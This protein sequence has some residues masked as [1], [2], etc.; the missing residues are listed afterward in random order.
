L[1]DFQANIEK[2]TAAN[3]AIVAAS[4]D[5]REDAEK[6]ALAE[7]VTFPLAF[8]LDA[9]AVARALGSF[10]QAEDPYLHATGFMLHPDGTIARGVYSTGAVGRITADDCLRSI[11]RYNQQRK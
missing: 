6:M 9:L 10:Y 3:A 8:G 1:A 7:G 2:L 5:G 11:S 4:V